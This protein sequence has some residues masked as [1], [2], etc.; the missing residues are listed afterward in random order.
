ML[1]ILKMMLGIEGDDLDKKL[2][3]LIDSTTARL[4]MLLGGQEPPIEFEHIIIEVCIARFNRIGS[5]GFA[6][7]SVE[8]ES[9]SISADDFAPY[10]KDIQAYLDANEGTVVRVRFL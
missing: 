8:G 9:F 1:D 6:N 2:R 3:W 7:H 10:E 5:E 4:R